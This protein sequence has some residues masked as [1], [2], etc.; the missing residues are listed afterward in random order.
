M[1]RRMKGSEMLMS[2]RGRPLVHGL[3]G[4]RPARGR[5][6]KAPGEPVEGEVDDG[7]GV[8]REELGEEQAA[9]D[10]DAERAPQ[11]GARARAEGEGQAAEQRRQRTARRSKKRYTTGV[12]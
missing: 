5:P 9:H 2:S 6:A 10:G 8:Q 12:V 7:C 1:G 4:D 3:G 11:L